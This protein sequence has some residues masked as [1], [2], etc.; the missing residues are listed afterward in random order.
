MRIKVII[1]YILIGLSILLFSCASKTRL[2]SNLPEDVGVAGDK[3]LGYVLEYIRDS[4]HLPSLGAMLIVGGQIVETE[5]IG[6]R[7]LGAKAK[8]TRR[9]RWHLGSNG[10]AMTATLGP[11]HRRLLLTR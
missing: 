1:T 8:V 11:H 6:V 9:D 4:Y 5:A 3:K 7:K 2:I 10:K